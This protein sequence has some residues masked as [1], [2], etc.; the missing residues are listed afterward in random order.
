MNFLIAQSIV[1]MRENSNLFSHKHSSS[2]VQGTYKIHIFFGIYIR[3]S[4]LLNRRGRIDK[5]CNLSFRHSSNIISL[6]ITIVKLSLHLFTSQTTHSWTSPPV[7]N[8]FIFLVKRIKRKISILSWGIENLMDQKSK[9]FEH[10]PIIVF[11][12]QPVNAMLYEFDWFSS[13]L[14]LIV[15]EKSR[16]E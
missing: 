10:T 11:F 3:L 15:I 8:V 13:F 5:L 9:L 16:L 6:V 4:L 1:E 7:V 14:L 2:F 12:Q